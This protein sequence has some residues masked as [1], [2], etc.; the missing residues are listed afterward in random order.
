[1][2]LVPGIGDAPGYPCQ[3]VLLYEQSFGTIADWEHRYGIIARSKAIQLWTGRN[4]GRTDNQPHLLFPGD[5]PYWG[6]VKRNGIVVACSGV[7]P[8]FDQM[9][10]GMT[11]DAMVALAYDAYKTDELAEDADLL[12]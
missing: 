12:P 8:W 3:P 9:I 7:Q 4:D 1:M 6:G 11:I 2:V 5:T 10:S